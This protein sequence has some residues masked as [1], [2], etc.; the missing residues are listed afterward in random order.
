MSADIFMTFYLKMT[1][2]LDMCG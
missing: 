2:E 1:L